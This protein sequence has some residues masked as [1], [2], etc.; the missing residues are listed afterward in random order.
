MRL[1]RLCVLYIVTG[2]WVLT[3]CQVV[4]ADNSMVT[5]ESEMTAFA[6]QAA[7]LRDNALVRRTDAAATVV[8]A[9]TRAADFNHYNNILLATVRA[10]VPPTPELQEIVMEEGV[11]SGTSLDMMDTSDGTMRFAQVGIADYVRPDDRCFEEHRNLFTAG[12]VNRLYLVAVAVNMEQGTELM[13]R[14]LRAGSEVHRSNWVAPSS[15]TGLCI[16]IEL[17]SSQVDFAAGNWSAILYVNG[18][19]YDPRPFSILEG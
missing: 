1:M 6:T 13:V 14:W 4:P 19:E 11:G 9:E 5:L 15:S 2:L 18:S 17:T 10:V 7:S 3:A 16:A 8:F 12:N